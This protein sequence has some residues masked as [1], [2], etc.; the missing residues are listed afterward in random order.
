MCSWFLNNGF[1]SKLD[2]NRSV[3]KGW[4]GFSFLNFTDNE[5]N[6]S[7]LLGESAEF[8]IL[9]ESENNKTNILVESLEGAKD[10]A[11]ALLSKINEL[12]S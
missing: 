6:D 1:K 8:R 4:L 3:G 2:T 7:L 11:E 5:S 10:E 12:L 9:L